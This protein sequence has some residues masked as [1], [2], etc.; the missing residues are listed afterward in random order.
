MGRH[1]QYPVPLDEE[2]RNW[3]LSFINKGD[4]GARTLKR[5]HM[6]LLASEGKNDRQIAEALHACAQ[7]VG[8]LRRKYAAGGLQAALHD[9]LRPGSARKLTAK[10]EGTLIALA[11]SAPPEGRVDWSM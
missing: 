2:E 7:T 6:L 9:R 5:A 3:L 4:S 10:G 11:C 1:Q 8:N